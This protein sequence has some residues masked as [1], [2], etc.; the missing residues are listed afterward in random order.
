MIGGVFIYN[1]KGE[2]LI[3]RQYR[4]DISRQA[5]DAFR[6]T[7]IHARQAIRSPVVSIA[8][9]NFCWMKRNNVWIAAAS[10]QN[11]HV[12]LVFELLNKLLDL[13]SSYFGSVSDESIKNNFVLI[14]ELLDEVLDFGYPQRTDVATLKS[15]ITQTGT[16]IGTIEEQREITKELTG[17]IGWRK[18]NIKYKKNEL[19]LDVLEDVNLLMSAQG[20][21]LSNHVSGRVVMKSYLSGM[22]ECKFGMN[23]KIMLEK[24]SKPQTMDGP[25]KSQTGLNTIIIFFLIHARKSHWNA[26]TA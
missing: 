20:Q 9:I 2:V 12:A 5:A 1:F 6:V 16:K 14:Y 21:V 4:D 11:L 8:R 18:E 10:K 3:S 19:F 25:K 7:V 17:Q 13:F 15:L 23:D 24:H 22:P 26:N